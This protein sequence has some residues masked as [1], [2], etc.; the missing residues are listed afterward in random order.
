MDADL[1]AS[2]WGANPTLITLVLKCPSVFS[3]FSLCLLWF[4]VCVI[5]RF[6]WLPFYGEVRA[7]V[8]CTVAVICIWPPLTGTSSAALGAAIITISRVTG[9]AVA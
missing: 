3:A 6:S 9:C 8:I 1:R 4:S 5:H 2:G 7:N